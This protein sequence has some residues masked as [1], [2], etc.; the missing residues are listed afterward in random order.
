MISQIDGKHTV[1]PREDVPGQGVPVSAR[2]EETM[3]HQERMSLT[4]TTK[5]ELQNCKLSGN[6]TRRRRGGVR[7]ASHRCR[8]NGL[9]NGS[10]TGRV[11][12]RR[13]GDLRISP[14]SENRKRPAVQTDVGRSRVHSFEP[15]P[16]PG[17]ATGPY[18]LVSSAASPS[19]SSASSGASGDVSSSASCDPPQHP[20]RDT[21]SQIRSPNRI[22][23]S[24]EWP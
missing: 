10:R 23:R 15:K 14:R 20:V 12:S 17:I 6:R 9:R 18:S 24:H 22:Q 19:P 11:R 5:K 3:E 16:V 2:P 1:L 13:G 7:C 8:G 21:R 4:V